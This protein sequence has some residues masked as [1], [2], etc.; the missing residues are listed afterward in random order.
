LLQAQ[1]VVVLERRYGGRSGRDVE[2][3]QGT[4]MICKAAETGF[5]RKAVKR[6]SELNEGA[7]DWRRTREP[8]ALNISGQNRP[9]A[10]G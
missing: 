6:S 1:N 3:C 10:Q 8:L 7:E 2:L 9:L 5:L 4:G